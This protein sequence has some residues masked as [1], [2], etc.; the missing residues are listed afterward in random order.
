MNPTMTDLMFS[1]HARFPGLM[2]MAG[3][4]VKGVAIVCLTWSVA[5]LFRQRSAVARAW[6]WRCGFMALLLLAAWPYRP[7]LLSAVALEVQVPAEAVALPHSALEKQATVEPTQSLTPDAAPIVIPKDRRVA[8]MLKGMLRELDPRAGTA[9]WMGFAALLGVKVTRAWIGLRHLRRKSRPAS[10]EMQKACESVAKGSSLHGVPEVR[11]SSVIGS[12]LLTGGRRAVI[13]LPEDSSEWSEA[14]LDAV[15]HHEIAHLVRADGRWQWLAG[16]SACF[17][18]W[19]PAVWFALTR[20]KAEAEQA[21]DEM[22]VARRVSACDYAQAL[23]EIASGWLSRPQP[24][25]GV[26]MLGMSEI[27][28]RVRELLR[29]HP[30]RGRL[31]AAAGTAIALLAVVMSGIVLVSCKQKPAAYVSVAKLVAAG[32]MAG[33]GGDT[34]NTYQDYLQDFYGTIIETI[35]SSEMRRRAKDRVRALYPEMKESEVEINVTQNKRGA[36]FNVVAT[37]QEPEFT[38]VFLNAVLDEYLAFRQQIREQNRGKAL[39]ALAEDVVK[40]ERTMSE[41]QR[42]LEDFEKNNNV[43]VLTETN[44]EL[45]TTLRKLREDAKEQ[46]ALVGDAGPLNEVMIQRDRDAVSQRGLGGRSSGRG[47]TRLEDDY[48][49]RRQA[50]IVARA[51]AAYM[52]K[53]KGAGDPKTVELKESADR[54]EAVLNALESQIKVQT[55]TEQEAARRRLALVES[56]IKEWETK[57]VETGARIA[58]YEML[59]QELDQARRAYDEMFDLVRRFQVSENNTGDTVAIMERPSGAVKEMRKGWWDYPRPKVIDTN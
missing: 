22:V 57:A 51:E 20:L 18:W 55:A 30:W 56:Q 58:S 13:W 41:K 2:E 1:L 37:G 46:R 24:A 26:P 52:D 33:P 49:Q 32:R 48:L 40:R 54:Q 43:V 25:L 23:I 50:L 4:L 35:E 11:V 59:K 47:L 39:T 16:V 28:R 17:W 38:R 6:V 27:E 9:W 45:A 5:L 31:G 29:E 53:N 42:R 8:G 10:R 21:A 44:N 14:K 36:I 3:A 15:W 7:M 19:N 34:G 12:P